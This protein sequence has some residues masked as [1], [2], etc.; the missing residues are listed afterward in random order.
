MARG[1]ELSSRRT[2][3][4]LILITVAV[5]VPSGAWLVAGLRE[6]ERETRLEEKGVSHKAKNRALIFAERLAARLEL[7]RDAESRRPFY[8]YQNLFHDPN[9]A[10]EGAS[11][12][13][14]PLAQ[15][16]V[17]PLIEVHFQVD[18]EGHLNLPTVNDEYP[19][20]GH[21]A[22]HGQHCELMADLAEVAVFCP[23]ARE[24]SDRRFEI[25][26]AFSAFD[27][28][29]RLD[30]S[31]DSRVAR[32]EWLSS[33]AWRQHLEAS[34]LYANLK[35]G[36]GSAL[37][38]FRGGDQPVE[39][40]TGPFSWHTLAVGSGSRPMALRL[41]ETPVGAWTQGFL[42]DRRAVDHYLAS[43]PYPA[44]F[45]LRDGDDPH[46]GR[47]QTAIS[48]TPWAVALD[49]SS[50]LD[51]TLDKAAA[52]RGRFLGIFLL[53]AAAAALSGLMVV[54]MVRQSE[55][56]AQQRAQF[57]ASAAHELRTP[58]AGLRLY[59]EMLAEGLGDPARARRYARRLAGEA[60]RLGR[61]VTNVLSFTRLERK[62]L[63]L[64]PAPGDLALAV[65]EAV[66]R[67]RPA[68]EEN[69]ATL[70]LDLP[71]DL[72]IVS[73]DRDAVVNVVQNL[74]D[75]AEKYTRTIEDR[76]IRVSLGEQ[77]GHVAL[78]VTDNG[79]GVSSSLRR[80]LFRPFSRGQHHDASEG[81]GLGLVLVQAL[82]Q[83]Q[84][85]GIRYD[86]A[87]GGGAQFTV[88]FPRHTTPSA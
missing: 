57:A 9:V 52:H 12:S 82:A 62:S 78:R 37:P 67:Q 43:A 50:Q 15:G 83:A 81:L 49:I 54:L 36:R 33:D 17:D 7:L 18:Q 69:G 16:G 10:A 24:D 47:V 66:E 35:Y 5:A 74:V 51:E 46:P 56:V 65:R 26:T 38:V 8:H 45:V 64:H 70:D 6:L 41:V 40:V 60:E 42:L 20:L 61:V 32:S 39:I 77:N 25:E 34:T 87:E 1:V 14:S 55:Q 88:T 63:S 85:G 23:L 75:N 31:E 2:V 59:G 53:G 19:E 86:D 73:F 30:Q 3:A 21:S 28:L 44:S 76:R 29:S 79:E 48:G 4:A 11:I 71:D 72:P 58:L 13:V 80:R 27:D 68:V 22:E 84:G